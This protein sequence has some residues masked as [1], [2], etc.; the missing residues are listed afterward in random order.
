[1]TYV[2]WFDDFHKKRDKIVQK[3]KN[4]SQEEIIEYFVFENMVKNEP[5]FCLLYK[6][7]KKCHNMEYLNCFFCACPYF[8]F[9]DDGLK[10][11]NGI[12]VKSRCLISSKNSSKFIYKNVEHCDC[13]NCIVPH[14]K[15]FVTKFFKTYR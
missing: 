9:N 11:E 2:E 4:R 3:F 15:K 7:K 1:M 13:S 5:D 6:E 12:T 8:E 10:V 14:T